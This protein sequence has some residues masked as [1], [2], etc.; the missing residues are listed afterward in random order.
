MTHGIARTNFGHYGRCE[1]LLHAD[2]GLIGFKSG[3]GRE[4]A[5]CRLCRELYIY[6]F[7]Q[8]IRLDRHCLKDYSTVTKQEPSY[9]SCAGMAE[10]TEANWDS[11]AVDVGVMAAVV[12]ATM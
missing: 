4:L 8:W 7:D 6:I 5:V 3:C 10:S 12:A 2:L 1:N 11:T 9:L